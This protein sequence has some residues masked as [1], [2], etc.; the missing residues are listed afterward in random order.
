M[1]APK[2]KV[3]GMRE[4][5]NINEIAALEPDMMGFIFFPSSSRFAGSNFVCPEF[6][7]IEKVGVFVDE[8]TDNILAVLKRYG[9]HTAQLHGNESP[10]TCL[11]IAEA[12]YKVMKAFGVDDNFDW[13]KLPLYTQGTHCFVF[14]T[15]TAQHGGSGKK[16]NWEVLD[17]Y[18]LSHPFLLSGG[19]KPQDAALLKQFDHPQCIGFDINSG[20]EV[21]PGVK[22]AILVRNFMNE[23]KNR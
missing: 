23:I 10:E 2:V 14:D 19:M 21:Q 7:G 6:S 8:T 9:M 18:T 20:F 1:K 11:T 22:D 3:C 13:E 5:T 4:A 17:K 15:K 12:G 16:F